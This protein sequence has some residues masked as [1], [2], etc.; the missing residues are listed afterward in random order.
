MKMSWHPACKSEK[1]NTFK[2]NHCFYNTLQWKCKW[3]KQKGIIQ[4]SLMEGTSITNACQHCCMKCFTLCWYYSFITCLNI[5][6]WFTLYPI[7]CST[8]PANFN[9]SVPP[10]EFPG[11][12][13]VVYHLVASCIAT[14]RGRFF[15]SASRHNLTETEW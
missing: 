2:Y 4:K 11:A 10:S 9:H 6:S 5:S 12:L 15:F 13:W 8:Q 7:I 1:K 3:Q 14:S